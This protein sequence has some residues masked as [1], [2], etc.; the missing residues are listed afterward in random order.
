MQN[1]VCKLKFLL[2][3]LS[4]MLTKKEDTK[5]VKLKVAYSDA[6]NYCGIYFNGKM[7]DLS[8]GLMMG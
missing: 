1:T 5:G 3:E 8:M 4:I 2:L 6:A 7:H